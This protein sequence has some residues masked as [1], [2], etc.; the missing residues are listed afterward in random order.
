MQQHK[1]PRGIAHLLL[2]INLATIWQ[3]FIV[4]PDAHAFAFH[5]LDTSDACPGAS[6]VKESSLFDG[7]IKPTWHKYALQ[8]ALKLLVARWVRTKYYLTLDADVVVVG[9]LDAA[10]LLPGGKGMHVPSDVLF[11]PGNLTLA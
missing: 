7:I 5:V 10:K 4:V 8:M 1:Y 11:C 2:T 3:L 6:I 9:C